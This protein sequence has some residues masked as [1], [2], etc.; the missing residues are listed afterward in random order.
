MSL[1]PDSGLWSRRFDER[2]GSVAFEIR[3]FIPADEAQWL[4]CRVLAFL[5]TAYFDDVVPSKQP[6]RDE[7]ELVAV[8]DSLIIGI[9][10]V[11]LE[12]AIATIDT[13]AV[14]PDFRRQSLA[15]RLLEEGIA[16][17]AKRGATAIEAWTRDDAWVLAWYHALGF[18]EDSHYLHVYADYTARVGEPADAV[19]SHHGLKAV[20]VFLHAELDTEAE[21]RRRFTRVHICRRLTR[22]IAA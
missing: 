17:A 5:D 4:R 20:K 1:A 12:G 7:I 22:P 19:T 14:H 15:T 10:D 13:I 16:R 21:M 8:H 2:I 9:L 3:E 18:V 11:T 6:S